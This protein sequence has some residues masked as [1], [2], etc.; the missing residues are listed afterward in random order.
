MSLSG[1]DSG[2]GTV[3][4]HANGISCQWENKGKQYMLQTMY[5]KNMESSWITTKPAFGLELV[6][7]PMSTRSWPTRVGL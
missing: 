3:P 6:A 4:R 2:L 1:L 7:V 5:R